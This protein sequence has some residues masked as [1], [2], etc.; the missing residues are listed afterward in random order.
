MDLPDNAIVWTL[1]NGAAR[2]V[3][4]AGR[5]NCPDGTRRAI[6]VT[7]QGSAWIGCYTETDESW[8]IVWEDG[9]PTVLIKPQNAKKEM[10]L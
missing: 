2:I 9:E 7:T 6:D 5:F 4:Q 8:T 10:T 1:N 3:L